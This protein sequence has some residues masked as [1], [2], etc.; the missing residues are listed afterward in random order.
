MRKF[1]RS[2]ISFIA[3]VVV[4]VVAVYING[5]N[6]EMVTADDIPSIVQNPTIR[7]FGD[8][9]KTMSLIHIANALFYQLF[10]FN[11]IPHHALSL[12]LHTVNVFL[13]FVFITKLF[14][15]KVGLATSLLFAVHP[16]NSEAVLWIS[17][18]AYM[19]TT[20]A[21]LLTLINFVNFRKIKDKKYLYY[22]LGIY[23]AFILFTQSPWML[24]VPAIVGAVDY[25]LLDTRIKVKELAV[26][27]PFVVLTGIY[28]L[29]RLSTHVSVRVTNLLVMENPTPLL[30]RLPYTTYMALRLLIFPNRLTIYHE[31]EI[32]SPLE[33]F[34]MPL[35][36][37]CLI[38]AVIALWKKGKKIY[39]GLLSLIYIGILPSFAPVIIAWMIAERYLYLPSIFFLSL[40]CLIIVGLEKKYKNENL[41]KYVVIVLL[42]VYSTRTFVRTFDWKTN[43]ALWHS[44]EKITPYSHRTYNNLGDVYS[45]EGNYAKAIEYFAKS[46]QVRPTYAEAVHNIGYTYMQ[47]GDLENAKKYLQKTYEMNPNLWHAYHKLGLI[48]YMEGDIELARGYFEKA[49]EV[50]PNAP[51]VHRSLNAL[52]QQPQ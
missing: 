13:V 38:V 7:D 10:E 30:N 17:A 46:V 25:F 21:T 20:L 34:L 28:W 15:K 45:T 48:A 37:I 19:F 8:S 23:G 11:P 3:L 26:Y 52:D 47:M 29:A 35:V 1:V 32:F 51:E 41:L 18:K 43:K 2:N 40:V 22:A 27:I 12:I 14:D 44:T 42:V 24:V 50:A 36:T 5:I 9:L 31:G 39:V 33:N 16:V 49:L 6:G 4:L